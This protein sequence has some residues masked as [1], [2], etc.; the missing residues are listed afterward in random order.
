MIFPCDT[1]MLMKWR[2]ALRQALITTVTLF[3]LSDVG[4]VTSACDSGWSDIR[5]VSEL[6][7]YQQMY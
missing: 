5:I 1:S 7:Q 6:F 2:R 4:R 3:R